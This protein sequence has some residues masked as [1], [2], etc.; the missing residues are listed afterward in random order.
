M[1]FANY[2]EW[3]VIDWNSMKLINRLG[4][5]SYVARPI[6]RLQNSKKSL[7]SQQQNTWPIG[8]VVRPWIHTLWMSVVFISIWSVIQQLIAFCLYIWSVLCL[9]LEAFTVEFIGSEK[10]WRLSTKRSTALW[11][12]GNAV[13][14][15][16]GSL[17]DTT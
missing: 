13:H 10:Q 9:Y 12:S 1:P 8:R 16:Y 14:Q 2:S 5:I 17:F 4:V 7:Y 15:Y 6:F 11:H 3:K